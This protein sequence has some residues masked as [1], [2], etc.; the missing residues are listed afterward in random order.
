MQKS[1]LQHLQMLLNKQHLKKHNESNQLQ[2]LSYTIRGIALTMIVAL[3]E[4][5]TKLPLMENT[6]KKCNQLMDYAAKYP[7]IQ[8]HYFESS[9][10]LHIDSHTT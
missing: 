1:N 5:V 2:V 10:I 8:L 7:T 6:I 9:M 3:N 4:I